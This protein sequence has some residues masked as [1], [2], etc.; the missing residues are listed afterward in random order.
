[1]TVLDIILLIVVILI[2]AAAVWIVI[3][4]KRR[5]KTCGCGCS[6]CPSRSAGCGR[7]P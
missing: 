6:D 4:N 5:G 2:I 3:R 1:M 7:K